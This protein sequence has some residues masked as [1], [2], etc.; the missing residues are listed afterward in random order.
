MPTKK[1]PLKSVAYEF[2]KLGV[3]PWRVALSRF[4]TLRWLSWVRALTADSAKIALSDQQG[5]HDSTCVHDLL[6]ER[7]NV[8]RCRYFDRS[9]GSL[10]RWHSPDHPPAAPSTRPAV[11]AP[12]AIG[13]RSH[14][15]CVER[16]VGEAAQDVRRPTRAAGARRHVLPALQRARVCRFARPRI[17]TSR[18]PH[19]PCDQP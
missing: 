15:G 16:T 8:D 13:R 18:S 17:G 11:G 2:G 7:L 12:E 10:W 3:K 9:P 4:P 1:Y 5:S 6:L 19:V 14:P